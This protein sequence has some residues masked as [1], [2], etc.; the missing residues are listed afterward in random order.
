MVSLFSFASN[1]FYF[2][3]QI[4]FLTS[5]G[6][7]SCGESVRRM[8]RKLGTNDLWSKY[9]LKGKK[10]KKKFEELILNRVIISKFY[11]L[12]NILSGDDWLTL[13]QYYF[14][15]FPCGYYMCLSRSILNKTYMIN[16]VCSH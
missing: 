14:I 9:S 6:G 3:H 16:Y 10:G 11:L 13:K 4:M 15:L 5:L 7:H 12:E 2:L 8:M 1:I